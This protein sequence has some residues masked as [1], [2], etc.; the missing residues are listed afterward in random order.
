MQVFN[1]FLIGTFLTGITKPAQDTWNTYN[2]CPWF[3]ISYLESK[4]SWKL[5]QR[6]HSWSILSAFF[7]LLLS[8]LPL[9][10]QGWRSERKSM[11][12]KSLA[13]FDWFLRVSYMKSFVLPLLGSF[14]L[15][16]CTKPVHQFFACFAVA[17]I[18][19]H[20]ISLTIAFVVK[21]HEKQKLL[22]IY[23]VLVDRP[24]SWPCWPWR[25]RR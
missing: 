9:R 22:R 3:S 11:S 18:F 1:L 13:N 17:A 24:E 7:L 20:T 4:K 2:E 16:W 8:G 14:R 12:K 10:P 19:G 23:W 6:T 5:L 25:P 15:S 21:K